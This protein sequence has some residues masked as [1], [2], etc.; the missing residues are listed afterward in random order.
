MEEQERTASRN[1]LPIILI[2]AVVQG[3]AFYGLHLSIDHKH[4][5][6]TDAGWMVGLY[7]IALFIPMSVQLLADHVRKPVAAALLA[8]L[9]IGLFYMGWHSGDTVTSARDIAAHEDNFVPLALEMIVLWLLVLPFI[10]ARLSVGSWRLPYDTLF[11]TAW[12]NKLALA[13]AALFTGALWLLLL[14]WQALFKLLGIDFFRDLFREPVFIYPVT[15]IAFGLALHLI[16]SVERFTAIVLEQLLN[17]LKWLAIVA[18]VILALFT[19]ALIFKLPGLFVTGQRAIGAAW[20]LWL[21]AVIV[22]LINAAYRDGSVERP[23]PTWIAISL[24]VV[25]PLTTIIAFTAF[26]ALYVRTSLYG[27]TVERVWA[28]IVAGAAVMYSIGYA[29]AAF[30][31]GRWMHDIARVNIIVALAMIVTISLA[32]TPVLSPYRLAANSQAALVLRQEALDEDSRN[33]SLKYL[34]FSAGTYG[35]AKLDGLAELDGHPHSAE[36]RKATAA[37]MAAKNQWEPL[38]TVAAE[39]RLDGIV[40]FP[41]GARIDDALRQQVLVFLNNNGSRA[42]AGRPRDEPAFGVFADLNSDA[43]DEFIFVDARQAFFFERRSDQWT[44]AGTLTNNRAF[45][46]GLAQD[47]AAGAVSIRESRWKTLVIGEREYRVDSEALSK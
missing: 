2:A 3:W 23:Y 36:I 39:E 8:L 27:L 32:L 7:S 31:G 40:L 44:Y 41:A 24:R 33:S 15:S 5:P 28:F 46:Q 19:V 30:R 16:G 22:L 38:P 21:V 42:L 1:A 25:V 18:G 35:R 47:F 37:A 17:V 11:A 34:R 43:T 6:A 9:A 4:W 45:V 10:Q 26:Y 13:E 12:R 14:L 29:I 20:L